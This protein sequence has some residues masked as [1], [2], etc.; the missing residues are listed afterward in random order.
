MIS[1]PSLLLTRP[2]MTVALARIGRSTGSCPSTGSAGH[3]YARQ[4]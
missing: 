2:R 1:G 4:P 3:R